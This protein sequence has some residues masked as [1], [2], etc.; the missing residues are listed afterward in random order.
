MDSEIKS[1]SRF[2]RKNIKL[3]AT[4]PTSGQVREKAALYL[5]SSTLPT[6]KWSRPQD[7]I[8]PSSSSET[9]IYVVPLGYLFISRQFR[10]AVSA[11]VLSAVIAATYESGSSDPARL[12][13]KS[14]QKR[15]APRDKR[16][17]MA[18]EVRYAI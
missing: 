12:K 11:V 9:A 7:G 17:V 2:W 18:L 15:L 13:S 4:P 3:P 1:L 14:R 16:S 6:T 5:T 10:T 8:P